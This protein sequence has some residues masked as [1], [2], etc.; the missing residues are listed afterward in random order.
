[1]IIV[2][3]LFIV[4]IVMNRDRTYDDLDVDDDDIEDYN[5]LC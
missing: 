4:V 1:M 2:K 3:T 5:S